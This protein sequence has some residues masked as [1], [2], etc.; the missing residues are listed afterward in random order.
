VRRHAAA[1]L[2]TTLALAQHAGEVSRADA[3]LAQAEALRSEALDLLGEAR[4]KGDLRLAITAIGQV[5]GVLELLARLAGELS[6]TTVNVVLSAEWA[7]VRTLV[8]RTLDPWPEAQTAIAS[9]LTQV[10]S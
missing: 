8:V 3:L 10:G 2:P 4:D 5:R 1:H 7:E 6:D 9:A